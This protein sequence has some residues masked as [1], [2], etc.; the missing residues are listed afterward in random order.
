MALLLMNTLFDG[1]M[2]T[3]KAS[4]VATLGRAGL[5][6]AHITISLGTTT[7]ISQNNL[8]SQGGARWIE[9]QAGEVTASIYPTKSFGDTVTLRCRS[10]FAYPATRAVEAS[11][12]PGHGR[13]L[14]RGRA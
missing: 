4:A 9:E 7:Q 13:A 6:Q 8:A 3:S 12:T 11:N 10:G 14:I 2:R 1:W 5:S